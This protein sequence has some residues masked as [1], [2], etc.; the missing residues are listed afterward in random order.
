MP[1][2]VA[3]PSPTI[4]FTVADGVA[5]IPIEQRAADEVTTMTGRT[6]DGRIETVHDDAG[7][8]AGRELRLRR[9]AGAACHR[10]DHRARRDRAQTARR[11]RR[12]FRR[13]SARASS[14]NRSGA[15][16]MSGLAVPGSRRGCSPLDG[17]QSA[18]ALAVARGTTRLLHSLGLLRGQR[19]AAAV[20]PA[21]RSCRA[22]RR[23]AKSGSSRSSPRWRIFA[24]TRNGWTTGCIATGCSSPPRSKCRA[25]FSRRIP[26]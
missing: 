18:T 10:A 17:R 11:L 23:R 21:R 5:E 8:L 19:I 22:R 25:R 24:P 14:A 4:D 7:R 26:A 12:L 15:S 16:A 6:A 2:Y 9:D 20:R 13:S 1:F 3:L